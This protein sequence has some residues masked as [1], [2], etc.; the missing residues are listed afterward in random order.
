MRYS[1][2][3]KGNR[4][5]GGSEDTA[6][7]C[8]IPTRFETLGF[9]ADFGRLFVLQQVHGDTS[10]NGEVLVTGSFADA[11]L[12]F[13]EGDVECPIAVISAETL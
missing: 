13:P 4:V 10:Q 6:Q 7:V 12:V 5:F 3:G 2:R 8:L 9:D 11:A 1:G